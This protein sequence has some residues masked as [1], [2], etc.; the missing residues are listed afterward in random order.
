M[1]EPI[2]RLLRIENL[3]VVALLVVA[4]L[5]GLGARLRNDPRRDGTARVINGAIRVGFGALVVAV[6]LFLGVVF[7]LGPIGLR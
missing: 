1:T 6:L 4:V 2:A 7:L 5:V 3:W